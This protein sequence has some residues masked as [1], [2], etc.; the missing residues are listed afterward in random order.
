MKIFDYIN[1]KPGGLWFFPARMGLFNWMSDKK[2]MQFIYKKSFK[3]ELNLD[4]PKT[5]T[6]K[7]AW[8]KL[9]WYSDLA[10]KCSDKY[11]V[12][13]YVTEKIGEEYLVPLIGHW[14]EIEDINFDMLPNQFVLK[15]T[16]GSSDLV[17]C[18]DKK[19]LDISKAK[20]KLSQN[21][22]A[23]YFKFSKEWVYYNLTK[24]YIAEQYIKSDDGHAIKDYKFFCFDG[25]PR[26]L[27]VGSERDIDVKFDFF[28][29]NWNHLDVLNGHDSKGHID[30]PKHFDEMVEISKKLSKDFPHVRVDL[31]EEQDKVYFGELTFFHFGG[32]VPFEPDIWD[33]K[34]GKYFRLPEMS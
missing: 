14:S 28:D 25:E 32:L 9:N 16:N 26:F 31:Y 19:D 3:R 10:V 12:R 5:Y 8:M 21:K 24:T 1:S 29:M 27:F 6:E 20:V 13:E 18:K 33:L 15:P 7:L 23:A 34:F 4:D 30:K 2:Y 11:R 22:A 17:I